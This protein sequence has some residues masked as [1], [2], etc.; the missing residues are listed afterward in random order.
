MTKSTAYWAAPANTTYET[1]SD[2]AYAAGTAAAQA[3]QKPNLKGIPQ[4]HRVFY[5]SAY[6][7]AL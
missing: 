6:R 1:A 2:N 7:R 4:S 5:M 3:G